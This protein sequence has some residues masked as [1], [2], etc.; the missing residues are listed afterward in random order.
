MV[1]TCDLSSHR[2]DPNADQRWPVYL[3]SV[4]IFSVFSVLSLYALLRLQPHLPL[5]NGKDGMPLLQ[6]FNTAVSFVTN[7]NWQSYSRRG[8][9][10]SLFRWSDRL[11]RT[12][13]SRSR[14]G[15]G[16]RL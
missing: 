3:R 15:G 12:L 4:L 5:A 2:V 10:V 13:V 7:T 16:C 8:P 9:R 1:R 11:F 14:Y 6:S